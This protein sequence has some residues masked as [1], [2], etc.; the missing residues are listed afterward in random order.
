MGAHL[1][2]IAS[3]ADR[4]R[5]TVPS[6]LRLRRHTGRSL[7]ARFDRWWSALTS[8]GAAGTS[9][10]DL[11][12]GPYWATVR[13]LPQIAEAARLKPRL[14]VASAGYGL[15]DSTA[16]LHPYSATFAAGHEDS[17]VPSGAS[18]AAGQRAEWWSR[19]AGVE[20]PVGAAPRSIT[21]LVRE[22]PNARFL[23]LASPSYV[24][25]LEPDLRGAIQ[26]LRSRE[27]MVIITGEPGPSDALLAESWI[28]SVAVLTHEVGGAL[29]ALH[30]R[31][32]RKILEEAPSHGLE[33]SSLRSLWAIRAAESPALSKPDREPSTDSEVKDFVK[34]ALAKGPG[35]H[36]RL[37]REYRA[38]GRA[39]EQ[40]RFRELFKSVC[41]RPS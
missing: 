12:V 13:S 24:D 28:T 1:H 6:A 11:Y 16:Q 32:A 27:R 21:D 3:C 22:E 7:A 33:A 35:T 34:K 8:V 5:G 38:S 31:V 26:E 10:L 18:D 37:L 36:S 29:P 23:I 17:I 20:G 40:S 2:I 41:G 15:V 30:A 19:L 14:W 39:C 25:A 9:A 4:K